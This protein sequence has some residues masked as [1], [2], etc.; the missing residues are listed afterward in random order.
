MTNMANTI[1]SVPGSVHP[2]DSILLELDLERELR[3][4]F[5]PSFTIKAVDIDEWL[6]E[7]EGN[8][9]L[10]IIHPEA[11]ARKAEVQAIVARMHELHPWLGTLQL[12]SPEAVPLHIELRAA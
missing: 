12:R 10:V 3:K 2:R 9:E 5:G 6:A 8:L 4:L 7:L 1:L 11:P